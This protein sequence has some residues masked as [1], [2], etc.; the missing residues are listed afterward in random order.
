MLVH[1]SKGN[2]KCHTSHIGPAQNTVLAGKALWEQDGHIE[3]TALGTNLQLVTAVGETQTILVKA[4]L[5]FSTIGVQVA[6]MELK[7]TQMVGGDL[8][9]HSDGI[10]CS[11]ALG[12]DT[13]AA[14]LTANLIGTGLRCR[15]IVTAQSALSTIACLGLCNPIEMVKIELQFGLFLHTHS[16]T[17][18]RRR[19]HCHS[20]SGELSHRNAT[21]RIGLAGSTSYREHRFAG[22]QWPRGG[23]H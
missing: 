22:G 12:N 11:I 6:Q 1:N 20:S 9:T 3:F 13:R 7:V 2:F 10:G 21:A 8:H 18:H 15:E 23:L 17:N 19:A 4:V 16:H 5:R 14:I